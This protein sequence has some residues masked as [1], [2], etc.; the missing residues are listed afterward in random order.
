MSFIQQFYSDW[1]ELRGNSMYISGVGFGG[2]FASLLAL[3]VHRFNKEKELYE[4]NSLI[5]LKGV[6]VAN[7]V[8]DFR[9]DPNRF[10]VDLL[11]QYSIIPKSLYDR[12]IE[13]ECEI[14]WEYL[15]LIASQLEY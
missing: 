10:T 9:A 5:N 12:Y 7:G 4:E 3:N 2:V 15:W 6:F 11:Y 1:P 13:K 8:V 14:K